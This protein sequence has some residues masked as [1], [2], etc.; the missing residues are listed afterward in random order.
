LLSDASGGG[1]WQGEQEGVD[2]E[3]VGWTEDMWEGMG[4]ITL[5]GMDWH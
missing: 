1:L 2:G 3:E 5:G 4:S